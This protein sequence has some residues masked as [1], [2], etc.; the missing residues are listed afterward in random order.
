VKKLAYLLVALG[1]LLA[2]ILLWVRVAPS[3]PARWHVDPV[4]VADPTTPNWA[5][6]A[7]GEIVAPA[8]TLAPRIEAALVAEPAVTLL[9]G[10]LAEGWATYLQRS[11]LMGYPDYVSIRIVPAGEGQETVAVL[12]RSR[13][14]QS[15]LGVN[16]AR[17]A[18][19]RAALQ[20]G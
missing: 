4:T 16:A 1:I 15:D 19:L 9:A 17:L 2:G 6:I 13:F 18:R 5:R 20:G 10:T 7:P 8:G 11:R 14:G 3:D 12:S